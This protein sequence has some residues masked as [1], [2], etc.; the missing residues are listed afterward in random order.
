MP[1]ITA[2]TMQGSGQRTLAETTLNGTDTFTYQTGDLLLLR[3][4]TGGSLSPVID[5]A[6]GTTINVPE[7]GP[8][9]VASGYAVGAIA[10]GSARMIPLDTIRGY[11]QGV[12]SILTGTGLVA[13]ILRT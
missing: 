3:N 2:T 12:V 11:C 4:P 6:D 10:A 5:G 9:S 13:S 1:A 8:V 7:L